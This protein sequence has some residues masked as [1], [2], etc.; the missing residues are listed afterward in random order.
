MIE[1]G[2][3]SDMSIILRVINALDFHVELETSLSVAVTTKVAV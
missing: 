1:E 2:D 3:V